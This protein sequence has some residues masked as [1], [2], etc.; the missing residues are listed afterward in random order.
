MRE[1]SEARR[2]LEEGRSLLVH[3]QARGLLIDADLQDAQMLLAEGRLDEART[4]CH[5]VIEAA[6]EA[7]AK[8]SEAQ[9]LGLLGRLELTCR[10]LEAAEGHLHCSIELAEDMGADYEIGL[11]LLTL[12]ELYA[13]GLP[14]G[15]GSHAEPLAQAIALFQAM[16]AEYD[17]KRACELR[18]RCSPAVPD[19]ST[20]SGPT[21]KDSRLRG[22][23]P[24][25]PVDE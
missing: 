24:L 22:K 25:R 9:G 10:N 2:V 8:V 15:S 16:G 20:I 11:A 18:N 4:T 13:L 5:K 6:R 12:A 23:T 3:A 14:P 19:S 7:G 17:L 21:R 1:L